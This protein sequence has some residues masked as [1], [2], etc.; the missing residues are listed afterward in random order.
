M[1]K[2]EIGVIYTPTALAY[3][4]FYKSY[5]KGAEVIYTGISSGLYWK[6]RIRHRG[7]ET[8][9]FYIST[10]RVEFFNKFLEVKKPILFKESL[11]G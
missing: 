11:D 6:F 9:Y 5:P 4:G 2:P 7:I 1:D 3:S 10:G 8:R